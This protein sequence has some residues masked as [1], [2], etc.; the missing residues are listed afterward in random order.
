M[1]PHC[2]YGVTQV[3]VVTLIHI[4]LETVSLFQPKYLLYPTHLCL[5]VKSSA[6][7][8]CGWK[9]SPT[10]S[11]TWRDVVGRYRFL[12]G[13]NCCFKKELLLNY[14]DDGMHLASFPHPGYHLLKNVDR[15]ASVS[16]FSLCVSVLPVTK[17]GSIHTT[18]LE[19][20]ERKTKHSDW[21]LWARVQTENQQQQNGTR[22][23][24]SVDDSYCVAPVHK[25][26]RV[27][28]WQMRKLWPK[29]NALIITHIQMYEVTKL[30]D[31]TNR[32]FTLCEKVSCKE[33]MWI[34][35]YD[36]DYVWL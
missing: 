5:H 1:R 21:L 4:C 28:D 11:M 24:T 31:L 32:C 25:P 23:W 26:S 19:N 36:S 17:W 27:W 30:R 12:F 20:C 33:Q 14:P 2:S 13:V 18:T 35:W 22:I 3:S 8:I 7:M 16:C 9:T 34:F 10:L 6:C 29:M 15:F